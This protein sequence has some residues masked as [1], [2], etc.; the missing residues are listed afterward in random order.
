MYKKQ[1]L[2]WKKRLKKKKGESS[3]ATAEKAQKK[4]LRYSTAAVKTIWRCKQ[5]KQITVSAASNKSFNA[6]APQ[7]CHFPA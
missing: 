1:K 6:M 4:V 5:A 3:T 7:H 2:L